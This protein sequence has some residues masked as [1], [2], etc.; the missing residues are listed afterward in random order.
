M[1]SYRPVQSATL[2]SLSE[3][4][5]LK[6]A[7]YYLRPEQIKALKLRAVLGERNLSDVVREAIDR[8]L[9]QVESQ[10]KPAASVRHE[11]DILFCG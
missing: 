2:Q 7:T 1:K 11:D 3:S 5:S 10:A 8:Y 9:T 4:D 6:R